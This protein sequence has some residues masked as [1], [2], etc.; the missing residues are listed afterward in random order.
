MPESA[1]SCRNRIFRARIGHGGFRGCIFQPRQRPDRPGGQQS[2]GL[3]GLDG[4]R[5]KPNDVAPR[6]GEEAGSGGK[7]GTERTGRHPEQLGEAAAEM[8]GVL[9]PSLASGFLH[10]PGLPERGRTGSEPLFRQPLPGRLSELEQEEA[11]QMP[12]ADAAVARQQANSPARPR[13][14]RLQISNTIQPASPEHFSP[15]KPSIRQPR[16]GALDMIHLRAATGG[17][18]ELIYTIT[19]ACASQREKGTPGRSRAIE[20]R[21]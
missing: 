10:E 20:P 1:I 14:P 6:W 15:H 19:F 18:C 16:T 9:E 13:S 2:T 5:Q 8:G 17:L 4:L 7:G 21:G 3:D 11:A 12:L